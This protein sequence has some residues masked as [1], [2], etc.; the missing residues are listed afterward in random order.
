VESFAF[1]DREKLKLN[2]NDQI[3]DIY[4]AQYPHKWQADALEFE[5]LSKNLKSKYGADFNDVWR[6]DLTLGQLFAYVQ[7]VRK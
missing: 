4:R 5:T 2:P 6:D 3:L 1:R 7:Q